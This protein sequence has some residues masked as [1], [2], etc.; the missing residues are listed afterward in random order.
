MLLGTP[1]VAFGVGG[2]ARQI[3]DASIVVPP[4]EIATFAQ[5]VVNLL[6]DEDA[7]RRL[8]VSAQARVTALYST[9]AFA[10][11]LANLISRR[12]SAALPTVSADDCSKG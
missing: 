9:R 2:V 11:S 3:G 12:D 5:E 6:T 7:R 10:A 8:G 1:V 4:G